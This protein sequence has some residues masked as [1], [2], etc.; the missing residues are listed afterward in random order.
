[1]IAMIALT[2]K[3][4][5]MMLWKIICPVFFEAMFTRSIILLAVGGCKGG[6][7][8]V[9]WLL[10]LREKPGLKSEDQY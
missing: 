7:R 8:G 10:V 1:M 3:A 2:K 5:G 9:K 4:T 6:H